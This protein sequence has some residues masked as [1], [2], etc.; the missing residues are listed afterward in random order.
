VGS[1][2]GGAGGGGC[3]WISQESCEEGAGGERGRTS[4]DSSCDEYVGGDEGWISEES[5]VALPACGSG[6]GG[7]NEVRAGKAR[8][9]GAGSTK[10]AHSQV[11]STRCAE[12]SSIN[13]VDGR[14][15]GGGEGSDGSCGAAEHDD[16]LSASW[17]STFCGESLQ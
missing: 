11:A 12:L 17:S 2:A 10:F 16:N 4:E 6:G 1:G 14:T 9:P 5:G 7:V 15:T 3:G 8:T 13:S